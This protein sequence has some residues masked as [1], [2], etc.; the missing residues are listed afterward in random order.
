MRSDNMAGDG[1]RARELDYT[2]AGNSTVLYTHTTR[3]RDTKQC[4]STAVSWL[5][6]SPTLEALANLLSIFVVVPRNLLKP[7]L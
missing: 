3:C 1:R 5:Y 2:A 6:S 4:K 7:C